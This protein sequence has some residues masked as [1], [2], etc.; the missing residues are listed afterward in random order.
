MQSDCAEKQKLSQPQK[1]NAN[2]KK[3][4]KFILSHYNKKIDP[5]KSAL[6]IC[7]YNISIVHF[8]DI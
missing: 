7:F 8:A 6:I 1:R 3:K 4:I 2:I 5:T